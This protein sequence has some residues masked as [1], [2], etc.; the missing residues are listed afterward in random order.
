M[1]V[2]KGTPA[3][4][5]AGVLGY[6]QDVSG[7]A[8]AETRLLCVSARASPETWRP[9]ARGALVPRIASANWQ[10]PLHPLYPRLDFAPGT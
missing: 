6:A 10:Y 3:P 1:R 5:K 2:R 7:E 4:P 8:R 9:L